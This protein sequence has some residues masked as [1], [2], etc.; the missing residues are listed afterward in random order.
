MKR[1][2]IIQRSDEYSKE[3]ETKLHQL[4]KENNFLEDKDYPELVITIGGDGTFLYAVH[5]YLKRSDEIHFIGIHTGTL[6]FLTEY[7]SKDIE[8]FVQ[9]LVSKKP[10]SKEIRLLEFEVDGKDK[11]YALNEIRIENVMKTQIL[12]VSISKIYFETFRGTGMCV[13][14]QTGSTAYNR[15][16]RGAVIDSD[17]ELIQLTEITGI[18]HRLF[19]SL[20]NPIIFDEKKEICFKSDSYE[21]SVLCYDHLNLNIDKAHEIKCRLSNKKINMLRFHKYNYVK[22]LK[23]L[24]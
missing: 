19:Q 7:G 21:G 24:F 13:S 12:D 9:D 4:L 16:L 17:L 11:H 8:Q 15:S 14:T 5:Q 10:Y 20:Q 18:H 23:N 22:R 1:Y 6:G 2:A 3:V